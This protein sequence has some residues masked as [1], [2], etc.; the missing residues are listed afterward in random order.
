MSG[1]ISEKSRAGVENF[2]E[3][4]IRFDKMQFLVLAVI[5][6]YELHF[7]FLLDIWKFQFWDSRS[8]EILFRLEIL[9][10]KFRRMSKILKI[11]VLS[12]GNT[13]LDSDPETC[14]DPIIS[15]ID[16]Y[17]RFST[18]KTKSQSDWQ[19]FNSIYWFQDDV[20][21]KHIHW[22]EENIKRK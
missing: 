14:S 12:E 18:G 2:A 4:N 9:E 1:K 13:D 10:Y 5:W 17:S 15:S 6:N 22:N 8:S 16:P 11:F 3:N 21:D 7:S 19:H 20:I